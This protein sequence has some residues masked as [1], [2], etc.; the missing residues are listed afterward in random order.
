MKKI[1]LKFT[2]GE[3]GFVLIEN[4]IEEIVIHSVMISINDKVV[5]SVVVISKDGK[6][7]GFK[8]ENV[9]TTINELLENLIPTNIIAKPIKQNVESK[10][11]TDQEA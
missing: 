10:P 3:T 11:N 6:H 4:K 1:K 9:F 8:E 2:K 7:H 5:V